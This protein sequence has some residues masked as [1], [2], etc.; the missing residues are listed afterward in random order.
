[1]KKFL[2]ALLIL[3]PGMVVAAP[4][5]T[6][7]YTFTPTYTNTPTG[8]NTPAGGTHTFTITRTHTFTPTY[9]MTRTPVPTPNSTG[10]AGLNREI[11][12]QKVLNAVNAQATAGVAGGATPNA[13]VVANAPFQL[14]QISNQRAVAT[15]IAAG[16]IATATPNATQIPALQAT[17]IA[18]QK[19]FATQVASGFIATATPNAT[20]VAAMV[21]TV[22]A[23]L[24]A[25]Q[26]QVFVANPATPDITKVAQAS[27]QL[28]A[29]QDAKAQATQ[30]AGGFWGTPTFT[31]T[32]T[33]PDGYVANFLGAGGNY[34]GFIIDL[35]ASSTKDIL[36]DKICFSC[37][38][39]TAAAQQIYLAKYSTAASG[40][41]SAGLTEM[42][43]NN[44]ASASTAAFVQ[45]TAV[46]AGT[47]TQVALMD[48]GYIFVP[49]PAT[50]TNSGFD[51]FPKYFTSKELNIFLEAGSAEHVA[52]LC[53]G[54]AG[55][56]CNGMI[57]WRERTTW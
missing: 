7:T 38:A 26:T 10:D 16:F 5:N 44:N 39:T 19:A 31:P 13:T 53:N 9:T 3:I 28:T 2:F 37:L 21:A 34:N 18:D 54:P 32:A 29:V 45:Y 56:T 48:M 52:L 1:M 27:W 33:P 11:T 35:P 47:G 4:T 23:Q 51:C 22:Q 42:P 25:V 50:A 57:Y 40:G 41:T 14:T 30:I 8:T 12:Q 43:L 24:N 36:I 20:Q 15:Q 55:F 49:A 6:M 17:Q 46:Q